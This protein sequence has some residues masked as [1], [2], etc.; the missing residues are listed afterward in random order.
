VPFVVNVI[1]TLAMPP[2][3]VFL[4]LLVND[5]EIMGEHANGRLSNFFGG[6]VTILLILAGIIFGITTVFP[7][8]LPS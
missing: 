1:A 6:T 4:L 8:L 5:R 2:A 3:I 7:H